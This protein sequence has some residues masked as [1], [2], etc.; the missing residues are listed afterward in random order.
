MP[1]TNCF[2]CFLLAFTVGS[3]T[4]F[5]GVL[6][7]IEL[8]GS[9]HG[10]VA[11]WDSTNGLL[12]V[13]EAMTRDSFEAHLQMM[14]FVGDLLP[15][16]ANPLF[17][18]QPLIDELSAAFAT[19][20]D[21]GP[22]SA[23][24][25]SMIAYKGMWMVEIG[26]SKKGVPEWSNRQRLYH[27]AEFHGLFP[28]L[29]RYVKFLAY[30]PKKPVKHGIK[31]FSLCSSST[32]YMHGFVIYTGKNFL[33]DD[34]DPQAPVTTRLF[35]HLT[36]RHRARHRIAGHTVFHDN[37]FTSMSSAEQLYSKLGVHTVGTYKANASTKTRE[38]GDFAFS[39]V[40]DAQAKLLPRG[41][42]RRTFKKIS[43]SRGGTV[44]RANHVLVCSQVKVCWWA[45]LLVY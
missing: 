5:F 18:L 39:A 12:V 40:P 45:S 30:M 25:E 20:Y 7:Y 35:L 41:W 24:D 17:K 6:I 8:W 44:A 2:N 29:G 27:V 33:P 42:Y 22:D 31:V 38:D 21:M 32:A 13:R 11:A 26:K 1:Q 37:W 14:S 36:R 43:P 34:C 16:P 23:L 4:T 10:T 3:F 9:R 28:S 19:N 15:N